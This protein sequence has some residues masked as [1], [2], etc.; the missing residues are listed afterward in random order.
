MEQEAIKGEDQEFRN[1]VNQFI[2]NLVEQS[3]I[4][5]E[6]FKSNIPMIAQQAKGELESKLANLEA[7][8]LE[9]SGRNRNRF[10]MIQP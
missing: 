5:N 9:D 1:H 3:Q 7:Y 6:I 10:S 8:L 2:V 4:E